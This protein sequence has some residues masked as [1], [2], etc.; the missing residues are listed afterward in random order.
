MAGQ[1]KI[2]EAFITAVR[3]KLAGVRNQISVVRGGVNP[4]N[5]AHP[6]GHPLNNLAV[7]PG[8]ANFQSAGNLKTKVT[9]LGTKIDGKLG[10]FDIKLDTY[11]QRLDQIL[12]SGENVELNNMSLAEYGKYTAPPTTV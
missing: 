10:E 5:E 1:I 2:D 9:G 7:V 4:G 6:H 8:H 11:T 3:D 12:E